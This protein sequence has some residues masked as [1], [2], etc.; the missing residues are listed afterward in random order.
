LKIYK[1]I[2]NIAQRLMWFLPAGSAGKKV[3]VRLRESAVNHKSFSYAG[4]QQPEASREKL[5]VKILKL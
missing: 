4:N 3:C 5:G 2:K 1:Y